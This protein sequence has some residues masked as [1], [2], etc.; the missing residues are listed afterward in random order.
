M[1]AGF[2]VLEVITVMF[3][4]AI[5][6]VL[7][8]PVIH[9]V[10]D[11]A[12]LVGCTNNLKGLHT[13]A[14]LYVQEHNGWPQI[15]LSAGLEGYTQR[16]QEALRPY[17]VQPINWVC[18]SIQRGQGSPDLSQPENQR[19]DYRA[20][21]FDSKPRTPYQW[22][23]MPWFTETSNMHGV[24]QLMIFA[25]G[26]VLGMREFNASIPDGGAAAGK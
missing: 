18:P 12:R 9:G 6:A 4:V 3:I 14:N 5:L 15:P 10:Q 13:A 21:P 25:D 23:N 2:T 16:W 19:L 1:D 7:A 17:G 11:R 24:G 26:R 20:M 8:L 22:S